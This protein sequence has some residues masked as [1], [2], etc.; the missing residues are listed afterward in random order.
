MKKFKK[1]LENFICEVCGQVV[2]GNGFTNHCPKCLWSKHV[3]IWPGDRKNPCQGLMEPKEIFKKNG[4]WRIIHLCQKCQERKEITMAI[5]DNW[6]KL[7]EISQ[8]QNKR[9][10]H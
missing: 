1:K 5:N 6:E 7:I 4:Q 9:T 8:K 3:D 2:K 10:F